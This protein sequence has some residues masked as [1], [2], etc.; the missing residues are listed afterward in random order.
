VRIDVSPLQRTDS[1]RLQ[2]Q[3]PGFKLYVSS[4]WGEC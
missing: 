1:R 4:G 2:T 3:C